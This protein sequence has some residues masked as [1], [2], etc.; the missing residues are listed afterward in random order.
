[1]ATFM[2]AAITFFLVMDGLGNVPL[3]LTSLRNTAPDRRR[4]LPLLA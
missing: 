2:S 1:M 4:D 3:F